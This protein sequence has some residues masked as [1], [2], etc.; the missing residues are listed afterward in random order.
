MSLESRQLLVK[1]TELVKSSS[2]CHAAGIN[3]ST[4]SMIKKGRYPWDEKELVLKAAEGLQS[5]SKE[6]A[7]ISKDL[8]E[9][10]K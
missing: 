7:K 10:A 3:Q 4:F 9:S 2:I 8:Q 6:L 5:I 1:A